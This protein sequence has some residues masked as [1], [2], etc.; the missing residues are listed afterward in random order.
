M[1]KEDLSIDTT[2]DPH[3]FSSDS[4]FKTYFLKSR[5]EEFW[6]SEKSENLGVPTTHPPIVKQSDTNRFLIKLWKLT[7]NISM[8][9]ALSFPEFFTVD[10]N[11][12]SDQIW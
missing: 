3:Y 2:F 11:Y 7:D 9:Q 12:N 6:K 5:I 8:E 4:T 1:L 10:K